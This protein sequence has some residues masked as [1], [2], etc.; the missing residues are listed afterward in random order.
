[1]RGNRQA[2]HLHPHDA[3]GVALVLGAVAESSLLAAEEPR[4]ARSMWAFEVARPEIVRLHHVKVAVE[5][6]VAVAC[7]IAPPPVSRDCTAE[8]QATIL[9]AARY[10]NRR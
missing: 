9:L 1:M 4:R 6:Q 3:I 8:R 2:L 5:D 10:R 7:H